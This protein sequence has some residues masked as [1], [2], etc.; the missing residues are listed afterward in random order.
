MRIFSIKNK[1]LERLWSKDQARGLPAD[2]IKRLR[3]A[4]SLIAAAPN[5]QALATNP[6]WRLHELKG[7]RKGT[8]SMSITGNWRLTFRVEGKDVHELDLEDYH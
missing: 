4:L 6:G 7:D 5:V 2:Q 3:A 8:W 1:A